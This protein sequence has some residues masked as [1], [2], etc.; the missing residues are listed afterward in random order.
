MSRISPYPVEGRWFRGSTHAHTTRSDGERTP[1]ELIQ[2]HRDLG[3]DFFTITD[4]R[5]WGIHAE[6][7]TKDFIMMQGTE[8]DVRPQGQEAKT[9]H[10]VGIGNPAVDTGWQDGEE[11][12]YDRSTPPGEIVQLLKSRGC[13]V[14]YAH[15]TW[16]Q[17]LPEALEEITGY[18]GIEVLNYG[19][20]VEGLSGRSDTHI[21]RLQWRGRTHHLIACDD[22]HQHQH[23]WGGGWIMVKAPELTHEAIF[24]ALQKGA[25]YATEGPEIRDFYVEDGVAHLESSPCRTL[26]LYSDGFQ[27]AGESRD[28][29]QL[30]HFTYELPSKSQAVYAIIKDARGRY[31]WSNPIRLDQK[32]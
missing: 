7:N 23:D 14:I 4:H 6:H 19:C 22:T 31:A 26:A 25:F 5:I 2:M 20:E 8:L 17:I 32:A 29:G 11:I 21:Q 16:S 18:D 13:Y 10:I 3:Y 15:P 9:H 12:V 28:D 24:A 1:A 27:C 30:T